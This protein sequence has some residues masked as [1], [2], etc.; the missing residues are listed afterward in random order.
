MLIE[1]KS[2][3]PNV[4]GGTVARKADFSAFKI[5]RILQTSLSIKYVSVARAAGEEDRDG[6]K[7]CFG[8]DAS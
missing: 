4:G 6:N 2:P 8:F 7:R 5:A 3:R 1:Q